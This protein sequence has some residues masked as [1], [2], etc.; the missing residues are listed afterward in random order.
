VYTIIGLL[1]EFVYSIP[2]AAYTS[3]HLYELPLHPTIKIFHT[4]F[5]TASLVLFY[6]FGHCQDTSL[7]P[8]FLFYLLTILPGPEIQP[9][10]TVRQLE[11]QGLERQTQYPVSLPSP[12]SPSQ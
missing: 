3:Y 4:N 11:Y 6:I 8:F 10:E 5:D 1:Y 9:L 7:I 2:V 12:L